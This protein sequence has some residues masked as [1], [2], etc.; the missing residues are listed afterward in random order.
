[1]SSLEKVIAEEKYQ[2]YQAALASLDAR[3]REL[4][5]ARIEVQWSLAEIASRFG[6]PSPD[7]ARMAVKRAL[8][9]L[10]ERMHAA[11]REPKA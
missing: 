7:A 3:D 10:T 9:R 5:V 6:L 1:M 8:T 11:D 4:I 2:R